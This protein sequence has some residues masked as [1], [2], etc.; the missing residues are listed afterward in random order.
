MVCWHIK[1]LRV[2]SDTKGLL[3]ESVPL[4]S[5]ASPRDAP[6]PQPC[7]R[8]PNCFLRVH[9]GCAL[10]LPLPGSSP[11]SEVAGAMAGQVSA[12][13]R[14]PSGS[15]PVRGNSAAHEHFQA[16]SIA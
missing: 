16:K 9:E 6:Q 1:K 13:H 12:K 11:P 2:P 4:E 8:L 3:F 10:A 15:P 5:S 14:P 7:P